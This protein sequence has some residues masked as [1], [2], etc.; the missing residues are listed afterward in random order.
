VATTRQTHCPSK[1]ALDSYAKQFALVVQLSADGKNQEAME[2]K[3]N[4]V[5]PFLTASTRKKS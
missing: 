1:R 4:E 3:K 2:L 5:D